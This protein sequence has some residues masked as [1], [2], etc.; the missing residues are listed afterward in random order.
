L[1]C[2]CKSSDA[3]ADHVHDLLDD[4]VAQ[5]NTSPL[6]ILWFWFLDDDKDTSL[7]CDV[8]PSVCLSLCVCVCLFV[9]LSV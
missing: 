8:C 6:E 5:G 4:I 3:L 2:K 9:Q 1:D 7:K